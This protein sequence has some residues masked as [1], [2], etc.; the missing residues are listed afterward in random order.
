MAI[1]K[2]LRALE[3]NVNGQEVIFNQKAFHTLCVNEIHQIQNQ[4]GKKNGGQAKLFRC[5]A[6][7]LFGDANNYDA[8]KNWFNYKNG[9]N[10]IED[11]KKLEKYF[12][13]DLRIP[14]S[15]A[16]TPFQERITTPMV[17]REINTAE[18]SAAKE[19]YCF[20]ADQIRLHQKLMY[21]YWHSNFTCNEREWYKYVPQDYPVLPDVE[22]QIWKLSFELPTCARDESLDLARQ[23][24]GY[25][26]IPEERGDNC[27]YYPLLDHEFDDFRICLRQNG[28]EPSKDPLDLTVDWFDYTSEQIEN[29]RNILDEIFDAYRR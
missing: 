5:L 9:P 4:T 25:P 16:A 6:M 19:L 12:R 11:V 8:I 7:Y 2:T 17:K 1:S 21:Y 29:Y 10:D 3:I 23:I 27:P 14:R 24:Y 15:T 20:M 26:S 13:A 22:N 28:I 18:L